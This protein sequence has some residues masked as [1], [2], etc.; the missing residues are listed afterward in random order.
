MHVGKPPEGLEVGR[1]PADEGERP[2]GTRAREGSH[3]LQVDPVG[4]LPE[5]A[6]DRPPQ[7]AQVIGDRRRRV[8]RPRE[9]GDVH[10]VGNEVR[11][12]VERTTLRAQPFRRREHDVGATDQIALHPLQSVAGDARERRVLVHA[13]IDRHPLVQP[14]DESTDVRREAPQKGPLQPVTAAQ[15]TEP[16][17]QDPRVQLVDEP[18]AGQRQ[19]QR[20]RDEEVRLHLAA[21][22]EAFAELGADPAQV[23]TRGGRATHSKRIHP[24]DAVR[25]GQEAH[26]VGLAGRIGAPVVGEADDG[27]A[28]QARPPVRPAHR[29]DSTAT[30]V[31]RPTS[32]SGDPGPGSTTDRTRPR[33]RQLSL[34]RKRRT[35]CRS[36]RPAASSQPR[37]SSSV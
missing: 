27:G 32:A 6:D 4:E 33:T 22:V 34:F 8:E 16:G 19:D 13:V 20:V 18:D 30:G 31:G 14:P 29:P 1:G 12:A 10:S 24:E 15:T 2:L 3:Q 37:R 25:L 17:G 11:V 21:A 36:T 26:D 23:P 5:E 9:V 28:L 7:P 35:T